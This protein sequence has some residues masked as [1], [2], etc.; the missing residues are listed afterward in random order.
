MRAYPSI[1]RSFG[2]WQQP[3]VP[4]KPPLAIASTP[5]STPARDAAS[6][7][8]PARS[9]VRPASPTPIRQPRSRACSTSCAP[10]T[11]RTSR[12]NGRIPACSR[13]SASRSATTASTRASCSTWRASPWRAPK[14]EPREQRKLGVDGFRLVARDVMQLSRMQL[15]DAQLARLGQDPSARMKQR[16]RAAGRRVLHRLQRA[17]DAAH[18][19]SRAR[20]HGRARRELSASWAGRA[21][22]AASCRCAPAM[23]TS[24]GRFGESTMDKLAK[25]KSGKVLAW[26]PTCFVQFNEFTL[27]TIERTRGA[28]PFEMTPF[29]LFLRIEARRAALA[30]P[31][32]G[33]DADRAPSPHRRGRRDGSGRGDSRRRFPA[34][35][36]SIS[37]SRRSV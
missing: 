28:R 11:G 35:N 4:S 29:L 5:C 22:A 37:A 10:A 25:S 19:A 32:S 9:P 13:A 1:A 14:N 33:S 31:P 7:S 24:S 15:T 34:S 3:W 23:S 27:P 8:R 30:V 16:R 12:A 17:Q 20:H 18:R 36:W 21:I 6:A 2:A 26:C